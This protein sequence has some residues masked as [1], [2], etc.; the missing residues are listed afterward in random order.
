MRRFLIGAALALLTQA[1][2]KT[3]KSECAD[4]ARQQLREVGF[5]PVKA[6][7]AMFDAQ[8]EFCMPICERQHQRAKALKA[9]GGDEPL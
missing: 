6:N 5:E 7:K 4:Y 8:V 2:E 1:C 3:C 9:S